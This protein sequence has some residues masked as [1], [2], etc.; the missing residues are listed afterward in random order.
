MRMRE[1]TYE[2]LK[3]LV[4]GVLNEH[5][6]DFEF[7]TVK[8]VDGAVEKLVLPHKESS[9]ICLGVDLQDIFDHIIEQCCDNGDDVSKKDV[10]WDVLSDCISKVM[11]PIPEH[12]KEFEAGNMKDVIMSSV[13]LRLVNFEAHAKDLETY[14]HRRIGDTDLAAVCYV[15][16]SD[17]ESMISSISLTSKNLKSCGLEEEEVFKRAFEHLEETQFTCC[18]LHAFFLFGMKSSRDIP[19]NATVIVSNEKKYMGAKIMASDRQMQ[20]ISQD[21][22]EGK[23]FF[24]IPSSIHELILFAENTLPLEDAA[25]MVY[26]INRA[27]VSENERLSDCIYRFNAETGHVEV[28]HR[29]DNSD[30]CSNGF[31]GARAA[32]CIR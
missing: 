19:R 20:K 13:Q 12:V 28:A 24:I 21:I 26:E 3:A 22:Y 1:F 15:D 7:K 4:E 18:E 2:N 16:I 25:N 9:N 17:D 27:E 8:K 11:T 14:A 31:I 32:A 6:V 23:S 29:A 10:A 30:L 5:N